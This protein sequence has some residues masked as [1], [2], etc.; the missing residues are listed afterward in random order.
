MKI[1]YYTYNPET[2]RLVEA[3]QVI[4]IDNNTIVHPS[5]EQYASMGDTPEEGAYPVG[6]DVKP[7]APEGKIAVPDG[8]C[9]DNNSWV[10]IWKF[11]DDV[12]KV[13]TFSKLALEDELFK[14]GL[15][16][17]LDQFVD[18]QTITNDHGQE[19][20]LR[21]KYSTANEFRDDHPVFKLFYETAKEIL[22]VT[23]EDAQDILDTAEI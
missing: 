19:M 17:K 7:I 3:P 16:E 10:H 2:K 22:G 18:S 9:L 13:R 6:K 14:R 11:V 5:A 1:L 21:R 15:L 8:Y 4:Q 20:P 12:K 23:D